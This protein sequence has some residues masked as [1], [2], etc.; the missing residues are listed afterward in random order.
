M[1]IN[2]IKHLVFDGGG[3]KGLA[4]I[5]V[6]R[7]LKENNILHNIKHFGGTSVGGIFAMLLALGYTDKQLEEKMLSKNFSQFL[8]IYSV[9]D[10]HR[11]LRGIMRDALEKKDESS[12][13]NSIQVII[14]LIS[15][16]WSAV[17]AK[18]GIFKRDKLMEFI[19]DCIQEKQ[20]S[21]TLS[22][23]ELYSSNGN[24]LAVVA[25]N[26]NKGIE[27]IFSRKTVAKMQI[28]HAVFMSACIPILFEPVVFNGDYYVD[29]GILNNYPI[30]IFDSEAPPECTLGFRLADSTSVYKFKSLVPPKQLITDSYSLLIRLAEIIYTSQEKQSFIVYN[31]HRT[32]VIDCGSVNIFSFDLSQPE[33]SQLVNSGY[34]ATIHYLKKPAKEAEKQPQED[35]LSQLRAH[36]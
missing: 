1:K 27:V 16:L 15:R 28:R 14:S 10:L 23:D 30:N 2:K 31:Q 34:E 29:G 11:L 25:C 20:F 36:L 32:V 21:K 4:Y 9:F 13:A 24:T 22:F 33:K 12:S 35:F 19:E 18:K 7:A 3:P 8:D 6:A 5:G 17:N 26:L